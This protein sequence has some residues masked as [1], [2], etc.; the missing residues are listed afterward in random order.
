MTK[1]SIEYNPYLVECVFKKNG[2]IL[3]DKSKIGAKS[4]VRLQVLLGEQGNWKGLLEEISNTC[5]DNDIEISFRGRQIDYDDLKYTIDLYKGSTRFR[6]LPNEKV[7]NDADIISGLDTIFS[8]IKEK[9]LPAFKVKNNAGKDIFEAYEEVKNGIFEVSVIATMSSGKSTLINSLLRTE[10]MPASIDACTGT[11]TEIY[12]KDNRKGYEAECYA[13]DGKTIVHRRQIVSAEDMKR[14]NA[15]KNVAYI[16]MEGS[17]A[18]ITSDK[19]QLCLYDTP[20]TNYS[21]NKKHKEL[22]WTVIQQ[23]NAVVLYI[24]NATQMGIKDDH[25]LLTEISR[26]MKKAGKQSR[27][28]FIFVVNKADCLDPDK[29]ETL[30]KFLDEVREYLA[31]FDIT[32]PILIPTTAYLAL[33]IIKDQAGV[34][35]TRAEKNELR[36]VGDYVNY[37]D[38]HF[39]KYAALTPSIRLSLQNKVNEY[40]KEEDSELEALIH[41]GVPAV[42]ETINEYIEKY[43]YPMKIKDAI[44]DITSIIDELDM[45]GKFERELSE[46][47]DKL[48][49][50]RKQIK[51]ANAKKEESNKISDNFKDKISQLELSDDRKK[52]EKFEMEKQLDSMLRE[53]DHC[54]K[55]DKLKADRL[56]DEFSAKLEGYQE[57][58]KYRLD[59]EINDKIYKKCMEMLEEYTKAVTW[60]LNSIEIDGFDFEKVSSIEQI[61]ISDIGELKSK[62]THERFKDVEKWKDNPKRKGFLGFFRVW[63]PKKISYTVKVQDGIEVDVKKI[64]VDIMATFKDDMN[65]NISSIFE[66]AE[67]QVDAYKKVFT[68]NIENLD[69]EIFN[70]LEDLEKKTK[71]KEA[72]SERV[73]ANRELVEWVEEKEKQLK[74]LLA[75]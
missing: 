70:I 73:K 16:K 13:E 26:E 38:Q 22:T 11:I 48:E 24:I 72:L 12:D 7:I 18:G 65:K 51:E 35:L 57:K 59:G 42:E 15:D 5:D 8:E 52:Y 55:I 31:Q 2:K 62:H 69:K 71:E 43:A 46:D 20:G 4:K 49:Q 29:G 75:F 14:Y 6:L 64:V 1:F 66:Q 53:Y 33:T 47:E 32:E 27:D 67:K 74:N 54:E 25:E 17:I 28:R 34:S 58:F 9:N 41:T 45:R 30:D 60:V 40:H 61:R 37:N 63:E 10:L 44:R 56:I 19:M 68:K 36:K 50:V 39:E 3:N 21:G 23:T